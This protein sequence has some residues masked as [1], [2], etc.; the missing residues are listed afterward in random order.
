MPP[1][2]TMLAPTTIGCCLFFSRPGERVFL[3]TGGNIFPPGRGTIVLSG[4]RGK[5]KSGKRHNEQTRPKKMDRPVISPPPI[6]LPPSPSSLLEDERICIALFRIT[7]SMEKD[8]RA[9]RLVPFLR[10]Y[11]P[12]PL[13]FRIDALCVR[14]R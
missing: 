8:G 13:A 7:A 3:R 11:P 12:L 1:S 9:A 4:D 14:W 5:G 2:I 6:F 10:I